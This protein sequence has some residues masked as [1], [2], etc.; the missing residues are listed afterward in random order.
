MKKFISL[1]F[2]LS[3]LA[4]SAQADSTFTISRDGSLYLT[5]VDMDMSP[6]RYSLE[7]LDSSFSLYVEHAEPTE[8]VPYFI[9]ANTR[10]GQVITL[11]GTA[12]YEVMFY[13]E[14]NGARDAQRVAYGYVITSAAGVQVTACGPTGTACMSGTYYPVTATNKFVISFRQP[15]ATIRL[16]GS[17]SDTIVIWY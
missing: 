12:E 11:P 4:C 7:T 14:N 5:F 1:L 9:A 8:L 15:G 17:T 2:V 10:N 3:A 16:K 13:D 6:M